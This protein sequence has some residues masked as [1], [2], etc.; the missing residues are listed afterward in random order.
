MVLFR[1]VLASLCPSIPF[2]YH[3]FKL[4]CITK[5]LLFSSLLNVH[6]TVKNVFC[7][8]FSWHLIQIIWSD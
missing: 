3:L 1:V 4:H 5:R 7:K 2:T 6:I 8:V